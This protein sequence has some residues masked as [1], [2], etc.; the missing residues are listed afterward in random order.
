MAAKATDMT[1]T[2]TNR[3]VAGPDDAAKARA[4]EGAAAAELPM[5]CIGALAAHWPSAVAADKHA[6]PS[7]PRPHSNPTGCH[8][9]IRQCARWAG[10]WV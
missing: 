9:P 3:R 2:T 8:E 7:L 6:C 4:N 5:A 10:F 1:T